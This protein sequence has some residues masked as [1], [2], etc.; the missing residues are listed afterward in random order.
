MNEEISHHSTVPDRMS[1]AP[2]QSAHAG[3]GVIPKR[4]WFL[5]PLGIDENIVK[6]F[7]AKRV[8]LD[9]SDRPKRDQI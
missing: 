3:S 1:D 7:P 6:Q 8:I 5:K 4:F 9:E 2:E